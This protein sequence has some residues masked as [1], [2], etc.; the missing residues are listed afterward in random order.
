M[1]DNYKK[2]AQAAREVD[3]LF[4]KRGW[5]SKGLVAFGADEPGRIAINYYSHVRAC[6]RIV[7]CDPLKL[8]HWLAANMEL[9]GAYVKL[10]LILDRKAELSNTT[11]P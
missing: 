3:N 4:I 1:T 8:I 10:I 6:K 9:P 5:M 7:L 2:S 11:Q